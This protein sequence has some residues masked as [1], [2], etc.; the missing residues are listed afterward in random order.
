MHI[1]E[2]LSGESSSEVTRQTSTPNAEVEF[3]VAIVD[4]RAEIQL[5]DKP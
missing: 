3:K 1:L 5:L 2:K 4:G